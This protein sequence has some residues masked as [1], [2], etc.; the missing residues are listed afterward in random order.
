MAVFRLPDDTFQAVGYPPI[1]AEPTGDRQADI[2][3]VTGELVRRL[4]ALIREHPDQWHVPH[5]IWPVE[6][7]PV[8]AVDA[9]TRVTGSPV[10][11]SH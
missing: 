5:R 1:F 2:R 7:L 4:E 3:R 8:P 9:Q 6:A 11:G 10:D